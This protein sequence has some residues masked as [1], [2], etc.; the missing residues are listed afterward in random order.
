M[1][2][3]K[4]GFIVQKTNQTST[5]DLPDPSGSLSKSIPSN[6]ITAVNTATM[7]ATTDKPREA[8]NLREEGI[9]TTVTRRELKLPNG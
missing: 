6:V 5:A 2:L 4:Y 8:P 3:F 9:T 1:I 7:L